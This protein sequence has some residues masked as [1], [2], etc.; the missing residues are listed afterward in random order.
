M[1]YQPY[2]KY[3]DSGVEWLGEIPEGWKQASFR[4]L[5]SE[6]NAGEVIDK[7]Y[8]YEGDEILYTC[9]FEPIKSTFADFPDKKRATNQDILLTR[10]GTPY[11]HLPVENAIYSN[12]VQRVKLLPNLNRKFVQYCLQCSA[13]TLIGYGVSIDSLN[14][15]LWKSLYLAVPAIP[16]QRAIAAFL[17]TETARID[18]LVKDYEELIELLKEKRQALISHAV[19]RGLSEL[20]SPDDPEFGEWAKPV[21][22]KDSGVEWIGEIPEGWILSTVRYCFTIGRGRVI[23]QEELI[24]DGLFPVFSSQTINKGCLG[25][26]NTY[27]FDCEQ[28]T[29]TTDGANAGTVFIRSGK[30]NCTNVCGTLQAKR[31]D[32]ILRYYY[33]LLSIG[34][35]YY[36]RPDTNGAK[37]MNNE[38]AVIKIVIPP[39][40][41]QQAIAM[42]L[43]KKTV[44]MET[45]INE[46]ESAIELLKEHR[47]ALITNAVTGKINVEASA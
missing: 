44:K 27:D 8:W 29:W 42:Y 30:H 7:S 19:T 41:I 22:F 45:L 5:V 36:K 23:S 3:K 13:S 2:P 28:I 15:E 16:T 37:I 14:Y 43:D 11:V 47:S 9:A 40:I 32:L 34:T 17:D 33:Y 39:M 1:K 6:N 46:A 20:V 35:E 24:E 21:K 10:N 18:G 31:S 4:R 25:Y 38:M 12:V 26:I